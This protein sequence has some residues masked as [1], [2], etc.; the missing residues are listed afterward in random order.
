MNGECWTDDSHVTHLAK[1]VNNSQGT[2][3]GLLLR[4]D[5]AETSLRLNIKSLSYFCETS[6]DLDRHGNC[7]N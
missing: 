1:G 5:E 7:G 4:T 2:N 6:N 3:G